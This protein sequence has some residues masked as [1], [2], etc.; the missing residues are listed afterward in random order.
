MRERFLLYVIADAA[1][2]RGRSHREVV[3]A[4]LAGGATAI[5]LRDKSLNAARLVQVGLELRALTRRH[6]AT[7]IVNDR[8]DIA[9]AVEADGVHLGLEDLPL[10]YAR[11]LIGPGKILGAT[12]R[13]PEQA[14]NAQAAGADY[15]GSGPVFPTCTKSDTG[16]LLGPE[17]LARI[18]RSVDIPV[19]GIGGI[20]HENVRAALTAGAAG[21]AVVSAIVAAEY[22]GAATR[23]LKELIELQNFYG[24]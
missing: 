18:C 6:R 9:L 10:R 7:F 20:K 19:I 12:A 14:V 15:V 21:V 24:T 22:I 4:A 17:G 5:Q 8:L 11:R 1:L 3:E 16:P 23:R 2:S 13:T